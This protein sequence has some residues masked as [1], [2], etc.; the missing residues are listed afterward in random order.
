MIIIDLSVPL[1]PSP[2][3]PVPVQMELVDHATG[4]DILGAPAQ[5]GRKDFPDGL[6]LSLEHVR[7]VSHAGTHVDAPSHYGPLCE[8]RPARAVDELPLEWFYG[9]GVLVRALGDVVDGP[10][11]RDEVE[12]ALRQMSHTPAPGEIILIHTGAD[13]RW[14][15]P[16]Y[17][18]NFRG[19]SV[20]ALAFLLDHGVK[21]V[22][23]DSF[24]FDPPFAQMLKAYSGTGDRSA[25]R[26][27]HVYGR[28]REYCQIER[29]AHLDRIPVTH[30][31][32]VA[33]FPVKLRGAGASWARVVAIV[34]EDKP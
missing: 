4:A 32:R 21:V 13:A 9:R 8:G 31:F 11:R 1:E 6:G 19:V 30:G 29:L 18:T 10:V 14:G 3:E 17:F 22:G 12:L 26:P 33:C 25:L 28:R 16:D 23:V 7:L 15:Q 2:G 34:D 24:G 5:I 27:A 20:E